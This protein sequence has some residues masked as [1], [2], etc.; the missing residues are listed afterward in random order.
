[1]EFEIQDIQGA[2]NIE[3][4]LSKLPNEPDND[5]DEPG[6]GE[7]T[8]DDEGS[9]EKTDDLDRRKGDDGEDETSDESDEDEKVDEEDDDDQDDD[10]QD[11]KDDDEDDDDDE[12]GGD[13]EEV[14]TIQALANDF[15]FEIEDKE[16]YPET[17]D[18]LQNMVRDMSTAIA[19]EQL[20]R[21]LQEYPDV[22]DYMKY[23]A[24]GGDP[25]QYFKA[26]QETAEYQAM[27]LS[28]ATDRDKR[29]LAFAYFK[30]LNMD[31]SE[32][33]EQVNVLAE[34]KKLDEP[35]RLK[36]YQSKLKSISDSKKQELA[37]QAEEEQRQKIEKAKKQARYMQ[38][39]I[40]NGKVEYETEEGER[41]TLLTI[42]EK[43]KQG[44]LEW[45]YQP[46]DDGKPR[47]AKENRSDEILLALE[48]I[49]YK[50]FDLSDIIQKRA[51]AQTL[52]NYR[53]KSKKKKPSSAMS[54]GKDKKRGLNLSKQS[55]RDF[56]WRSVDT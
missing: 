36:K 47:A 16:R 20:Q 49:R 23:R 42:P 40:T 33:S 4:R 26:D 31:D 8:D 21:Q 18:G 12:E 44:F 50:G 22:A 3:E 28:K 9:D 5:E 6:K 46:E 13:D 10:D 25:N 32:A 24:N 15:G 39:L 35:E 38:S 30:A 11:D 48:Y 14:S 19:Q 56:F 29:N 51:K 37:E 34:T 17:Y 45:L 54:Q 2:D 1:M 27:D 55:L 7:G 52:S 41:K 53:K 43:D